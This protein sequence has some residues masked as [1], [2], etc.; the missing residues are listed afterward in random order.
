MHLGRQ[1]AGYGT[2]A[3]ICRPYACVRVARGQF[4]GHR[5]AVRDNG[6]L[7]RN[8]RWH[9]SGRGKIGHLFG[10]TGHGIEIQNTHP[11]GQAKTVEQEPAA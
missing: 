8:Q 4:L 10:H 5:E 6:P 1:R 11:V 7:W 3:G 9:G 2:G